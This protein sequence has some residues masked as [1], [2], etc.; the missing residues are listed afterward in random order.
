MMIM[1]VMITEIAT[2]SMIMKMKM[3]KWDGMTFFR[4]G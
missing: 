2:T 3:E 1:V 4:W